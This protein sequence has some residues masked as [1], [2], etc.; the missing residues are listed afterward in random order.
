MTTV[1][2]ASPDEALVRLETMTMLAAPGLS[3]PAARRL[4]ASAI[5]LIVQLERRPD[6]T[7]AVGEIREVLVDAW[8]QGLGA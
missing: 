6:G 3:V 7:R 1:H 8:H 5:E 2:A 4:V